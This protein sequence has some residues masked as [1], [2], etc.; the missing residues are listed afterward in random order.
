MDWQPQSEQEYYEQRVRDYEAAGGD[1]APYDE[2]PWDGDVSAAAGAGAGASG[3]A[4]V[5]D[6]IRWNPKKPFAEDWN[7]Y[8][9]N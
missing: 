5:S 9:Q 1:H 3:E 2:G 8:E 4:Y 7:D 6:G